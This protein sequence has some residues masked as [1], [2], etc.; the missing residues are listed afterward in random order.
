MPIWLSRLLWMIVQASAIGGL[1]WLSFSSPYA[2]KDPTP[3]QAY[4]WVFLAWTLLVAFARRRTA[5][6][7]RKSAPREELFVLRA[8]RRFQE[9]AQIR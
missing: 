8:G 9:V 2:D 6:R 7:Q 3:P 4:L 1:M 5:G